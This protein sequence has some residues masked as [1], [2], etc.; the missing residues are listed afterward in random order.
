MIS[1]KSVVL[2]S[3]IRYATKGRSVS[4]V[5]ECLE[6]RY[7]GRRINMRVSNYLSISII[8]LLS[9]LVHAWEVPEL[10]NVQSVEVVEN[11]MKRGG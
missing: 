2:Y 10:R 5:Y 11:Q 7:F 4:I 6:P 8:G 1:V 3:D 9:S